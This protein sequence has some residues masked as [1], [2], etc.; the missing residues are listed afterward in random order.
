MTAILSPAVNTRL[1]CWSRATGWSA[2]RSPT[3]MATGST[4]FSPSDITAGTHVPVV[5]DTTAEAA[6]NIS[7]TF[8]VLGEIDLGL[9]DKRDLTS[10]EERLRALSENCDQLIVR[11]AAD[12]TVTITGANATGTTQIGDDSF[13]IYTL[14][15][16][17][18]TIIVD[19]EVN[20]LT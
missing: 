5:S 9:G 14:G 8:M 20:V 17:G 10:T 2:A 19:D 1:R 7:S 18:A 12:D 15:T 13:T 6:G 11:C 3:A 16:D 4:T